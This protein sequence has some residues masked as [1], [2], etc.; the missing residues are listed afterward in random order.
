M[1]LC[2]P[3]ISQSLALVQCSA[4]L[5]DH[6]PFSYFGVHM[7]SAIQQVSLCLLEA[8]VPML[9][10]PANRNRSAACATCFAVYVYLVIGTDCFLHECYSLPYIVQRWRVKVHRWDSQLLDT[11][12]LILS[13]WS[14]V[15]FARIHD[16]SHTQVVE[17]LSV[18]GQ[19]HRSQDN[20][21]IDGIPPVSH[22]QDTT[23]QV[24]PRERGCKKSLGEYWVQPDRFLLTQRES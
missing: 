10:E 13:R 8:H 12:S 21:G 23:E 20:L 22:L 5:L 17:L 16:A 11:Q 2:E 4:V 9:H 19:R 14:G 24:V 18:G 1:S 6:F 3:S 15:F 7:W